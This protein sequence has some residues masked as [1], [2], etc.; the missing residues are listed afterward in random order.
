MR[1]YVVLDVYEVGL[2]VEPQTDAGFDGIG[3]A[4]SE[5]VVRVVGRSCREKECGEGYV[6]RWCSIGRVSLLNDWIL[7]CSS[8]VVG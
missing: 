1:F 4:A 2:N 8:E 5:G 7:R 6:S 3:R